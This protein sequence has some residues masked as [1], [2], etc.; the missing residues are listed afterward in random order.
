LS[1]GMPTACSN[2]MACWVRVWAS[3]RILGTPDD[4]GK[5]I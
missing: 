5:T 2:A 1:S 4:S 3:Q